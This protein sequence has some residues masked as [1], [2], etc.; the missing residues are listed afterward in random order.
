[1]PKEKKLRSAKEKKR[2]LLYKHTNA[3]HVLLHCLIRGGTTH[4]VLYIA[5]ELS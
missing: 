2:Q 4:T 1:M 5:H 3:H